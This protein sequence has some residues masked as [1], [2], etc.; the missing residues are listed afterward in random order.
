MNC[1]SHRIRSRKYKKYYY[2]TR[3][4]KEITKEECRLC[5]DKQYK[6]V[7]P[8]KTNRPKKDTRYSIIT[9]DMTKCIECGKKPIQK[10]EIFYGTG[11]RKKSIQ[12]GLVIPLCEEIH[13]NGNAI[14]IHKDK[15]LDTKWKIIGQKAFMQHYNKTTDEFR[16][17]FG[18]NYIKGEKD[19]NEI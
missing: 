2:C 10:H 18:K 11:K 7:K 4:R 9:A 19:G 15:E 8:L 17:I 3:Y 14:G 6:E 16:E 1:I 13:H 5:L 12:Y